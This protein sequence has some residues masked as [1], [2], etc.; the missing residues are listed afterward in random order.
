KFYANVFGWKYNAYGPPGFF[1]IDFGAG[2]PPVMQGSLQGRRELVPG[3][4]MTGFECTVSV[5]DIHKAAAAIDA[6]GGKIVMPVCTLAGIGQL[7]FFEDTEGNLAGAM[8]YDARA[9]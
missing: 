4:R 2:A 5:D 7:L 1:M 8:Q 9:E 6:N 3:V